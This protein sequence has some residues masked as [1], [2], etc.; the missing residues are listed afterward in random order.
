MCGIAGIVG[1]LGS[2]SELSGY[3][4]KLA[5]RLRRRGPDA[6]GIFVDSSL[7]VGLT[8]TRLSILDLSSRADQPMLHDSGDCLVFNGE[9]YNHQ[10]LRNEL[11]QLGIAFK[12]TSDTEV[13]L[14]AL[15]H[16]GVDDALGKLCGMFAFAYLD[17]K[18]KKLHLARDRLGEKPLFYSHSE[19]CCV[20]G[21]T[22]SSLLKLPWIS[23]RIN[24]RALDQYFLHN[25]I[26]SGFSFRQDLRK[27]KPGEL[28]TFG[29]GES[30]NWQ[31]VCVT[32]WWT[33]LREKNNRPDSLVNRDSQHCQDSQC[34]LRA[35]LEQVISET[36]V[37]DVEVGLFLSGGIDSSLVCAIAQER[38]NRPIRSFSVGF[39]E[40]A[41]NESE[42]AA[43][44]A[45]SI[46]TKHEEILFSPEIFIQT[47]EKIGKAYDEP[48]AD[49]SQLPTMF[50]AQ[51][52]RKHVKVALTGDGGDEL[53]CGYNR[54]LWI[55]KIF[56]LKRSIGAVG[57]KSLLMALRALNL[58]FLTNLDRFMGA[59]QWKIFSVGQLVDKRDKMIACI[60]AVDQRAAYEAMLRIGGR[61]FTEK[62]S[63]NGPM[64]SDDP[65]LDVIWDTEFSHYDKMMISDLVHYL[66]GDILTKVDRASMYSSLECRAPLIDVRVV[67]L[68]LSLP[69]AEKCDG[70][71]G[72][73]I[74]RKLL[75][76]YL[77]EHDFDT[78]KSGF[79]L[80]LA[81]WLRDP[82]KEWAAEKLF[83]YA[84]PMLS[85]V[86]RAEMCRL[87]NQHQ[88]G[89][90][91][92]AESLWGY[93]ALN[94][95]GESHSSS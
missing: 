17:K 91:N 51:E 22:A 32:N 68:A 67:R 25:Y 65:D 28:V 55:P 12:T 37:A 40:V 84:N 18:K 21:S 83:G 23:E 15:H 71:I 64:V 62:C 92:C 30:S 95:W 77:P 88:N 70:A 19:G 45:K 87:W 24:P 82:L 41:Y 52:A 43:K 11:E 57:E 80:P 20:F 74:L 36:L 16:W 39:D 31:K 59:H 69:A 4:Q 63:E 29:F 53:F 78:R 90:R 3:L 47:A 35:V 49:A 14:Q 38:S 54:Y 9:I 61:G 73:I 56:R 58:S 8:Q 48:F 10:K 7:R 66:P 72:K 13:L 75:R 33:P 6:S 60:E 2:T 42:G 5:A 46:G 26:P 81:K 86:H 44:I 89:D 93:I 27:V 85:K 34:E 79:S 94:I 76:E 1:F 50:L